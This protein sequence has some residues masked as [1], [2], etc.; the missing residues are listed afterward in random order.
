VRGT[1]QHRSPQRKAARGRDDEA[2]LTADI[3]RWPKTYDA[4]ILA[5]EPSRRGR[6]RQLSRTRGLPTK[7]WRQTPHLLAL[8]P[9]HPKGASQLDAIANRRNSE[10]ILEQ[11]AEMRR[12]A[13]AV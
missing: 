13:E 5:A 7:Q 8:I 11:P 12:T 10:P 4:I 2:D 9:D 3:M 6:A 1:G